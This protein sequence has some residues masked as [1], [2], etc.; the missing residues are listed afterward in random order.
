L[1]EKYDVYFLG[2]QNNPFKYLKGQNFLFFLHLGGF[3]NI[4]V[5]AM[6]CGAPIIS[7]DCKSGPREILAPDTDFKRRTETPEITEYG[8]LMPVLEN[9]FLICQWT[10]NAKWKNMERDNNKIIKGRYFKNK[11]GKTSPTES[12]WFWYYQHHKAMEQII[13]I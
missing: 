4:L 8:V 11:A 10:I 3:S 9:K 1:G 2:F 13:E 12:N 5:E 7:S 6:I